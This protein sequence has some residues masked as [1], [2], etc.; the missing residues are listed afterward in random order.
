MIL[1]AKN[2]TAEFA[3]IRSWNLEDIL[4]FL[5]FLCHCI[6][7]AQFLSVVRNRRAAIKLYID[8]ASL[9]LG[10]RSVRYLMNVPCNLET[11][12]PGKTD[13]HE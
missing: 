13:M 12:G 11:D 2:S 10:G 3:T 1:K 6:F 5:L 7:H 8:L 4:L 9:L